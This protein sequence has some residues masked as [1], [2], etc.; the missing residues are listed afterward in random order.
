MVSAPVYFGISPFKLS[1]PSYCSA[2]AL[3]HPSNVA[4]TYAVISDCH[5][6]LLDYSFRTGLPSFCAA[7]MV[8][9][10]GP[11][12]EFHLQFITIAK[13]PLRF[14]DNFSLHPTSL[15][16]CLHLVI[17]CCPSY[18]P[19]IL[20]IYLHIIYFIYFFYNCYSTS[21]NVFL[22]NHIL[23]MPTTSLQHNPYTQG[24]GNI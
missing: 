5:P 2:L 1:L 19:P 9:S 23:M 21:S 12:L 15:L 11:A 14:T 8:S 7:L 24:P 6:D 10:I 18:C 22:K 20:F 3:H 4:V 13:I 17:T 16:W